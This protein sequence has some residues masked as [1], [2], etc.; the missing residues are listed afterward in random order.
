V[1]KNLQVNSIYN[2]APGKTLIHNLVQYLKRELNFEISSLNINFI[3][4]N[5]I[6]QIN[7]DYL[8]QHCSTDIITFNYTGDHRLL[9]GELYISV[10]DGR[11][12]AKKYGVSPMDEYFRLIIHGILHLLDYD[13]QNKSDKFAMK[14]LENNLLNKYNRQSIETK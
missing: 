7:K 4:T 2:T 14:K 3:N 1:V 11:Q 8:N 9:E 13:D 5:Q 12:N 10:E 6:T